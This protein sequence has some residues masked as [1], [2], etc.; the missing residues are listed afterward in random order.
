MGNHRQNDETGRMVGDPFL[1]AKVSLVELF[2]F[3]PL[4]REQWYI[5]ISTG[6]QTHDWE[7][8]A[9][10]SEEINEAIKQKIQDSETPVTDLVLAFIGLIQWRGAK[11]LMAHMQ[12][13][14]RGYP[15]GLLFGS[16]VKQTF[17][18]RKLRA[19]GGFLVMGG[20]QNI[21]I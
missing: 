9:G 11:Q 7:L 4:R 10:D 6:G 17:F 8:L 12:Y 16:H 18:A 3:Q 1:D 14:R 2:Q 13:F 19:Y 5:R 20:C 21:W 15:T